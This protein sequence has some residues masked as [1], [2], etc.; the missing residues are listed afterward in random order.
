VVAPAG[1]V[2]GD[3]LD[4]WCDLL[5][6]A[7]FVVEQGR[8]VRSVDPSA[9]YLAGRD[10]E[11]A[12]DLQAA[13][14]DPAVDG[15]VCAR[16]GYGCARILGLLDPAAFRPRPIVGFSDITA[17]HGFLAAKAGFAS[18]HGP[19]LSTVSDHEPG[20]LYR[21]LGAM[22]GDAPRP[23]EMDTLI[24]G[25]AS[26]P[27]IGGNLTLVSA[28]AGTD[29]F[30]TLEGA[31]VFLEEVAEAPYRIDRAL[32]SLMMRGLDKAAGVVFGDL[33]GASDRYVPEGQVDACLKACAIGLCK[34]AGIPTAWGAP[35]GHRQRNE[36][37]GFGMPASLMC[38]P[39][40]AVLNTSS[41]VHG[42][43][44]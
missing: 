29:C 11:R 20:T 40:G 26:G 19:L 43:N 27:L 30:P 23:L 31:I 24:E 13:F 8:H 5:S 1:R 33:G 39:G 32:N 21:M 12:L 7:G 9:P 4:G 35:I 37:L 14:T 16:G 10:E 36:T 44:R 2:P 41:A 25:R 34:Q 42:G 22:C 3:L 38:S 18:L 17:L 15:I 28:L 6:K